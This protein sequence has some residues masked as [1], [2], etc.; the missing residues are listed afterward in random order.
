MEPAH[1]PGWFG[2]VKPLNAPAAVSA[3]QMAK[4]K[5]EAYEPAHWFDA[6]FAL[7]QDDIVQIEAID[8]VYRS[9]ELANRFATVRGA[10]R[11]M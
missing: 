2:T 10:Q 6:R 1:S 3:A 11:G 8:R 9:L 5:W 4:I 7:G